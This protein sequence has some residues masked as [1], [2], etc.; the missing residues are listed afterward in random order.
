M[1]PEFKE[2]FFEA[3]GIV[4]KLYYR[5][6][7]YDFVWRSGFM[8]GYGDYPFSGGFEDLDQY[9]RSFYNRG[10]RYRSHLSKNDWWLKNYLVFDL[11]YCRRRWK[12]M[13]MRICDDDWGRC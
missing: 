1:D 12:L 6:W 13:K 7:F 8:I 3:S 4:I 2:L 10:R 11:N 5:K 9:D